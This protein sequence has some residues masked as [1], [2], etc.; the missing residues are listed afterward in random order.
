MKSAK[1]FLKIGG[2]L[3]IAAGAACLVVAY[4]DKLKA[5]VPGRK[6]EELP[7]EFLDYADV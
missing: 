2:F 4:L 5:L 1:L 6:K 3:L 7:E